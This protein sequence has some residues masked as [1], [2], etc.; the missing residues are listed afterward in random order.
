MLDAAAQSLAFALDGVPRIGL[1]TRIGEPAASPI[2]DQHDQNFRQRE[3]GRVRRARRAIR[4]CSLQVPR[5]D[6][7]VESR[8]ARRAVGAEAEHV[9]IRRAARD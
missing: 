2:D 9:D 5:A 3:P 4:R 8:A 6:V 1:E 7:G